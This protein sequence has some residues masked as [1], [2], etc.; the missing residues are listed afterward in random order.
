M[1][2]KDGL[3]SVG[4][5]PF[6]WNIVGSMTNA[7]LTM[8]ITIVATRVAGV[9][10]GGVL[11]VAIGLGQIFATCAIY[12]VRAYQSTDLKEQFRFADYLGLRILTCLFTIIV[13]AWYVFGMK[14]T[15]AKASVVY[16]ICIFK[17]SDAFAD[18]FHGYFQQHGHLEYA[19]QAVAL[20]IIS[21]EAAYSL[22]L[23]LTHDPVL[24]AWM[25]PVVSILCLILFEISRIRKFI[26]RVNPIFKSAVFRKMLIAC[27]PLFVSGFINLSTL[28]ITK[29]EVDSQAPQLQGYWTPIYMPASVVNL[30]GTFAF[31]PMVTTLRFHWE[32]NERKSFFKL[33]MLLSGWIAVCQVCVMLGGYWLGIPAL[34]LVYGLPLAEYK[35]ALLIVL[36]GGGFAALNVLFYYV[37]T[38]IRV[39]QFLLLG[40]GV[41]Y[42]V[43]MIIT[44]LLVRDSQL[45]GAAVAYLCSMLTRTVVFGLIILRKYLTPAS[46]KQENG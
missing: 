20:R 21:V 9:E 2:S 33:L 28:N 24:S 45:M 41:T 34:E 35:A 23:I 27:F 12:E 13:C 39:Q 31:R 16:A 29:I 7:T 30:L 14:Y 44:P 3:R 22:T 36:V 15:G 11:G 43:S 37:I 46:R 8:L 19:G 26:D 17:I 40:D 6:F 10:E 42:L 32:N 5:K 38:I 4:K 18:V 1:S 25:M